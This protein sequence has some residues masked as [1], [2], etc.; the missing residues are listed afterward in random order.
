MRK[1][2]AFWLAIVIPMLAHGAGR[3]DRGI[4]GVWLRPPGT[5]GAFETSLAAFQA[6]GITDV[7]LETFYWGLSTG[8]QGVFNGRFSFDYLESAINSA[9]KY[10][11]RLH[12]WLESSYWQYQSVGAYNFA[13]NP[14]WQVKNV[15]TG[16]TGG[17]A[18]DQ[19]FANLC[20]PGVQQKLR[21]Y[22]AEL[23]TYPGLWGI[24]TDY[25]RMPIDNNSADNFP[26]PWS[27]DTYSQ[28]T[29]QALTGANILTQAARTN[30][31]FWNQF[32]T[33]RRNG[34]S[35]A[36]NQMAQGIRGVSDDVVFSAAVFATAMSSS[37]QLSKCQD[38]PS[39]CVG[40][41]IDQVVPMAYGS[42]TASIAS[43]I[44]TTKNLAAGKKVVAGLALTGTA[45]HPVPTDQ[46][47]TIKGQGV[48][49]FIFF[50]GT[51]FY[52]PSQQAALKSWL[53]ANATRHEADFNLNDRLDAS[54][55]TSMVNLYRGI[56]INATAGNN[57][58]DLDASGQI[59]TSDFR[60]V[61][62][63]LRK[64]RFGPNGRVGE[65]DLA[66]LADA[67]GTP[68]VAPGIFHLYD[69]DSDGD[70]DMSDQNYA[71]RIAPDV[72]VAFLTVELQN[73]S[74]GRNQ[75]FEVRVTAPGMSE[76]LATLRAKADS[77]GRFWIPTGP[78]SEYDLS[79]KFSH[80]L[81]REVR[82]NVTNSDVVASLSLQN[83]DAN[84]DNA[85]DIADYLELATHFDTALG[86]AGY[87]A[88][89][90]LNDDGFVELGDYLILAENFDS[91]GDD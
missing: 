71:E 49:D 62:S 7:Y 29:F 64:D 50:D 36:A 57:K 34:V 26:A 5:I 47:T 90:D 2:G 9:A 23:A 11:I 25:H 60:R 69:L 6:S 27:Y 81:R 18:A 15:A 89:S 43:D 22:C 20:H 52:T 30:H 63:G 37:A 8:K 35:E 28:S 41:F 61:R 48:E 1:Q 46:L 51:Y 91:A 67:I 10:G 70:V 13:A 80:F 79:I 58:Y 19:I 84:G 42:T 83:G 82:V 76:P 21:A 38:W 78:T 68:Q 72:P 24:Q 32:L 45:A 4:R 14:D 55:V 59:D 85:V 73:T 66:Q 65:P 44:N 54:D 87:A 74:L 53:T 86:D 75:D 17:D 16:T 3:N 77:Q 31:P 39:W 12:A 56:P 88:M 40:N 33:W